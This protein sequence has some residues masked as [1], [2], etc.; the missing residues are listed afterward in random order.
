MPRYQL[1]VDLFPMA[2]SSAVLEMTMQ[3]PGVWRLTRLKGIT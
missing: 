2:Y 3:F 1:A